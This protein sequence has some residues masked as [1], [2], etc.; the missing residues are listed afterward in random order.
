MNKVEILLLVAGLTALSSACTQPELNLYQSTGYSEDYIEKAKTF[1]TR[2]NIP[3]L[4]ATGLDN[5]RLH[6]CESGV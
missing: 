5:A 6:H 4:E 2:E 3:D 1:N